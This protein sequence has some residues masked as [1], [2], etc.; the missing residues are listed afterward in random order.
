M[1]AEKT[2]RK[3]E[4]GPVERAPIGVSLTDGGAVR[5]RFPEK[6]ADEIRAQLREEGFHWIGSRLAW[7]HKATDERIDMCHRLFKEAGFDEEEE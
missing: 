3:R 7:V 2:R 5:L 1:P 6:P 4:R